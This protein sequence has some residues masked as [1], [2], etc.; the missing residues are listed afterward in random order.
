[1]TSLMLS[2][3]GSI[4]TQALAGRGQVPAGCRRAQRAAQ[5]QQDA[6]AGLQ[7]LAQLHQAAAGQGALQQRRVAWNGKCRGLSIMTGGPA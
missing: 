3:D 5:G 1:M 6:A 2:C 4:V 7:V